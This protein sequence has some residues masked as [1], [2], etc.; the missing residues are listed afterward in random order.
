VLAA[1]TN[2][3]GLC[4]PV[5]PSPRRFHDRDIRVLGAER[6]T[7]A[8]TARITDPDLRALLDRVGLRHGTVG[9]LPGTIDQATDSTDVLGSPARFRR[10]AP[11]LG[12]TG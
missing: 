5:D 1:A 6:L 8:L 11:L 4:P 3:L 7:V 2:E 9:V 10:A 12:L